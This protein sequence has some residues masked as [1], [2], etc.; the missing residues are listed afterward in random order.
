MVGSVESTDA[1]RYYYSYY[2]VEADDERSRP[3]VSLQDEEI[4]VDALRTTGLIEAPAIDDAADRGS[5][6]AGS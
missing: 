5:D 1:K 3:V 6:A 2:A 4:S